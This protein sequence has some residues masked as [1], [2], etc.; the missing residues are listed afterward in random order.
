MP[1][2]LIHLVGGPE[3]GRT[4]RQP[5]RR[6]RYF[7]PFVALNSSGELVEQT[8]VYG[9]TDKAFVKRYEKTLEG[10]PT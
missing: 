2:Y 3:D 7:F 10:F 9:P 6:E 4:S 8:L 5:N 1:T